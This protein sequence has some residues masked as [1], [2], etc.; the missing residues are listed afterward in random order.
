MKVTGARDV[1]QLREEG[2]LPLTEAAAIVGLTERVLRYWASGDGSSNLD[3]GIGST[4]WLSP[5]EVEW[6]RDFAE[7][8]A[9]H[10]KEKIDLMAASPFQ[11]PE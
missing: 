4:V 7:M 1:A 3:A 5:L 11:V 6:L 10:E 8:K 9:R 2:W